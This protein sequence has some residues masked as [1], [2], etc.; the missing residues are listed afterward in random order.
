VCAEKNWKRKTL[1]HKYSPP[2]WKILSFISMA[3]TQ[4]LCD[5]VQFFF[6][7]IAQICKRKRGE[8]K[9]EIT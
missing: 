4:P 8:L 1:N 7:I 5:V 9:R 2:K 3:T 6:D